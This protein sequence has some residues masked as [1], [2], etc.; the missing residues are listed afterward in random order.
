LA[1]LV[2]RELKLFF[3]SPL[4]MTLEFAPVA[5]AAYTLLCPG[6]FEPIVSVRALLPAVW[7]VIILCSTLSEL[8]IWRMEF[9]NKGFKLKIYTA[10]SEYIPF[11][12]HSLVSLILLELKTLIVLIPVLRSPLIFNDFNGLIHF[13]LATHGYWLFSLS[14]GYGLS[15]EVLRKLANTTAIFLCVII[16]S[17][18]ISPFLITQ[19]ASQPQGQQ[20]FLKEFTVGFRSILI[21]VVLLVSLP[22]YVLA[23]YACSVETR[24]IRI[25]GI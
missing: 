25:D 11:L 22:L 3:T 13:L 2:D 24:N 15:K 14:V 6:S 19:E 23:L 20:L 21:L 7:L 18:T 8:E 1:N 17:V 4:F 12:A 16:F 9:L 10:M 5:L